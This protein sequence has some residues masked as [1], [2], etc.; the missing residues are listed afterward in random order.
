MIRP[1][2]T[3]FVLFGMLGTGSVQAQGVTFKK[4]VPFK[5]I[6]PE[7]DFYAS[8]RQTIAPY[9]KPVAEAVARL[10][11][12]FGSTIPRG[13]IFICST[14]E[15]KD[16]IYEPMVLKAGYGWTLTS[17]TSEV[18][19]QEVMAR[20]KSQMGD[21]PAE[22]RERLTSRLPD[23]M[24]DAEKQTAT[25]MTQQIAYAVIQTMLVKDL[26]FR[27]SRLDDMGKSP[28]PDWLDISIA[29]YVSGAPFDLAFLQQHMDQTF[30]MEDVLA[31]SRPFVASS[32]QGSGGS[33]GGGG[34]NRSGGANSG[35]T[36]G[37]GF[38]QGM[39]QGGMPQGGMPQGGM[40]QGG[41]P[42]GGMPQGGMPQGGFSGRGMGGAGLG[43][44][45]NGTGGQRG[46]RVQPK[47]E[48]DRMLFDS[49]A[50]TFFFYMIEKLGIDK[51]K[52]LVKQ[53]QE[54]KESREFVI[55][56][57]VL[58]SNF[59]KIEEDWA[60]WVK[61]LKAPQTQRQGFPGPPQ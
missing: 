36:G 45:G 60:S 1:I 29:S 33:A 48:Q 39:P 42:Q 55:Q 54:G 37:G 7:I 5:Q 21:I 40:A 3:A 25:T 13:A 38:G 9:E 52:Q 17:I 4:F 58:G 6:V 44:N 18:R 22:I 34:M 11:T 51:V 26:K 12:I 8:S 53:A 16:S 49:Q 61:T 14:L 41:M 27:S 32:N 23:M 57:D 30:P 28:L 47:D 15:Q 20:M 56:P 31:M 2:I 10:K 46:Q 59:A 35:A 50:S 43:G 24:A 19:M